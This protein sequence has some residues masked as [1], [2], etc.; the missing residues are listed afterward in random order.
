MPFLVFLLSYDR[1]NHKIG[2]LP[3]IEANFVFSDP[4]K[5]SYGVECFCR[6]RCGVA[7]IGVN[8]YLT[9]DQGRDGA[10]PA[11]T[12]QHDHNMNAMPLQRMRPVK[13]S[14]TH[15]LAVQFEPEKDVGESVEAAP[16]DHVP[17]GRVARAGEVAAQFGHLPQV[18][19]DGPLGPVRWPT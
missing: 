13:L 4:R 17:G 8:M 9:K 11:G 3:S 7:S 6:T 10:L 16:D 14:I 12:G 1:K 2:Y 15:N 19:G 5:V 18:V